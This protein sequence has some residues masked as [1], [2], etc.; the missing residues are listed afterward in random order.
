MTAN[1]VS[2]GAIAANK[3]GYGLRS[4]LED[5]R[6]F[7]RIVKLQGGLVPQSVATAALGVSRQ[8]VHQLVAE[9]TLSHW[10]F[11]GL[12]WLSEAELVSFAK[13]NRGQGE[14]QYK[15]GA[16]QLWKTS[17]ETGRQFM[18]NRRG[19]VGACRA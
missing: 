16:K 13:L 4:V 2:D 5:V 17:Q 8:R 1:R 12:N 14:N 15:P 9:G 18:K 10:R 7:R 3:K 6:E 11:Y 19:H